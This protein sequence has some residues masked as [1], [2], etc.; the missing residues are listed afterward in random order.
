MPSHIMPTTMVPRFTTQLITA[1]IYQCHI[2]MSPSMRSS[3]TPLHQ[4]LS[5]CPTMPTVSL[6]MEVLQR[7]MILSTSMMS[8]FTISKLQQQVSMKMFTT[9][10]FL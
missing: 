10:S 7:C 2:L 5:N 1:M 8:Y 9:V 6:T 3:I 4:Q